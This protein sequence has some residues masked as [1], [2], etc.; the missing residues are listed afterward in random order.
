[1]NRVFQNIVVA[2]P[3]IFAFGPV[4]AADA[5]ALAGFE[6]DNARPACTVSTRRGERKETTVPSRLKLR[7]KDTPMT[8][9]CRLPGQ[10]E[11]RKT[12]PRPR[13]GWV[14]AHMVIDDMAMVFIDAAPRYRKRRPSAITVTFYPLDFERTE[15]IDRWYAS[16]KTQVDETIAARQRLL[17]HEV[18]SCKY[19][20]SCADMEGEIAAKKATLMNDLSKLRAM[21]K[22]RPHSRASGTRAKPAM[23][24]KS[25]IVDGKVQCIFRTKPDTWVS[26]PCPN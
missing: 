8:V 1:M 15:D 18:G 6:S 14:P 22:I 3:L 7:W 11:V 2:V 26:H 4:T 20:S 21:L 25:I 13:D 17:D 16:R 5:P 9:T 12:L 19:N 10:A 24:M 23:M